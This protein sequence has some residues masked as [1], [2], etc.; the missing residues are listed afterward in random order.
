[1]GM[2]LTEIGIEILVT[3]LA[4]TL[5]SYIKTIQENVFSCFYVRCGAAPHG[6]MIRER[7]RLMNNFDF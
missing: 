7:S 4:A 2:D 1:M 6:C 5:Y 3:I